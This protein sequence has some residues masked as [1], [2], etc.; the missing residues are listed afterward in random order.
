ME[1]FGVASAKES[2]ES[3]AI[4]P[5]RTAKINATIEDLKDGNSLHISLTLLLGHCRWQMGHGE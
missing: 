3:K 4:T 5:G 1:A 2:S